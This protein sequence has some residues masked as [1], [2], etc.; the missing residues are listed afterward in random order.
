MRVLLIEN[1]LSTSYNFPLQTFLFY[2]TIINLALAL[3][4]YIPTSLILNKNLSAV[5]FFD[6]TNIKLYFLHILNF[7][8]YR[9]IDINLSNLSQ[10]NFVLPCLV[11]KFK[12]RKEN[13]FNLKKKYKR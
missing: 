7:S 13:R 12:G 4:S 1:N 9:Y 10:I 5:L 8:I 2:K 3:N 6:R 11:Y